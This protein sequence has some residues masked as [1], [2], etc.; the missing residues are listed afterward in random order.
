V[1]DE[2]TV[3]AKTRPRKRAATEVTAAAAEVAPSASEMPAT[4]AATMKM[5]S[6]S[7]T[8]AMTA[9]AMTTATTSRGSIAGSRQRGRKNK[10]GNSKL[11]FR[12]R[13]LRGRRHLNLYQRGRG[14]MV[15]D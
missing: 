11:E 6:A 2:R 4:V 10:D 5:P 14:G 8:A 12:H 3:S 1:D 7:V 9:T 15:P 13:T